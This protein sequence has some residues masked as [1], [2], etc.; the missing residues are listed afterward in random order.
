MLIIDCLHNT[1]YKFTVKYDNIHE[2]LVDMHVVT[3]I[4]FVM[5]ACPYHVITMSIIGYNQ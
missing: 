1:K 4:R 3:Y 5:S 2:S